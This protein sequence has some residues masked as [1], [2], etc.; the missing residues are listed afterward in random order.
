MRFG[1]ESAV[2]S[3]GKLG[4]VLNGI[5]DWV[6]EEEFS[7]NKAY[8]W[9]PS[10]D[11]I[12]YVKFD[13][14]EVDAYSF[15]LYKASFPSMDEN[16]LY[17]GAYNYKYP[18]AGRVNSKVSVHVFNLKH[19]TTKE[20][21]ISS[22]EE[23]YIPRIKFTTEPEKLGIVKMNRLQNELELLIANTATGLTNSVFMDRN[24]KFVESEHLDDILFLDGGKYFMY[25]GDL[26]G[27]NHIHVYS[28]AGAKVSQVTKGKWVV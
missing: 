4:E 26:D 6:N 28:L 20:M 22:N 15:S 12:A 8:D 16:E 23:F 3:G 21:E 2:T 19:R 27:Y 25:I 9:S 17:P 1:S 13:E 11:E 10:S 14:R 7:Y 5:P 18:K 24:E